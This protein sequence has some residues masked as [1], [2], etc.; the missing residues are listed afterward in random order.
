MARPACSS[1]TSGAR[2]TTTRGSTTSTVW[3]GAACRWSGA[4]GL[5]LARGLG[6]ER[7]LD[8]HVGDRST[9]FNVTGGIIVQYGPAVAAVLA[10]LAI[11]LFIAAVA[12]G[13]R[14]Q[15]LTAR[16]LLVG[17]VVFPFAAIATTAV[18]VVAWLVVKRAVPD[19]RVLT[20]GTSQNALFVFGLVA[21]ALAVF[22]A[23][24]QPLLRRAHPDNLALGALVWW[25]LP[26]VV[27]TVAAPSAAYLF[28]V[29]ALATAAVA[30]WRLSGRR[31]TAWEGAAGV[32]IPGAM[33]LVVYAPVMLLFAVLALRLDGMG[34]P[35]L[36]VMALFAALAAGLLIPWLRPP[37][38]GRGRRGGRW[39]VPAG[40]AL[41]ALVLIA[42]GALRL[43]YTDRYP[44][45]DFFS[46][47]YDAD[48]G[49]AAYEAGDRES[50][51]RPLL[52]HA[53]RG[54]I[55][56]GPFAVF[57]GW[58]AP[59][60]ALDLAGPRLVPAARTAD[61]T[62]TTLRLHLT[63]PRGAEAAAVHLRAP[64]PITA[65]SVQGRPI[66]VNRTM[67]DGE[68][69]LDYSASRG[70]ASTS[71]SP[72]A[73]T[74]PSGPPPATTP[75]DSRTGWTSPRVRPTR[76]PRPSASA[77]T[78]PSSSRAPPSGSRET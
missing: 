20:V 40:A 10:A 37:I 39:V 7:S 42:A 54:D 5:A 55:E 2:P 6:G 16:G 76:C 31:G 71:S 34:M 12:V 30:L 57:P 38:E 22:A 67:H 15:R 25:L 17:V 47:V 27:L 46:Y 68:L 78:R 14:R 8:R 65:A 24:Y 77:P 33:L 9:Y 70:R 51:S 1:C 60:P 62:T 50:W 18:T 64:G 72:C 73:G 44:R 45:P 49:R 32:G 41:I 69:K 11:A 4:Y 74:A 66:A 43:D 63:S 58:R 21:L 75:R 23:L 3:G 28:T 61:G 19:L 35:V 52:E 29:P 56:L 48:T 26:A 13:L 59:A 53:R 36:G